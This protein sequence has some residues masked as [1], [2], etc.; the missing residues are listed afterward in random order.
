MSKSKPKSNF[1]QNEETETTYEDPPTK[2][3]A[4]QVALNNQTSIDQALELQRHLETDLRTVKACMAELV[5]QCRNDLGTITAK[6]T[7]YELND[8]VIDLAQ[9]Q[10]FRAPSREIE[11]KACKIKRL[12]QLAVQFED[13]EW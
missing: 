3:A 10:F 7:E 4:L 5:N 13:F 9:A 2:Q 11:H 8:C 6:I 12:I 1:F